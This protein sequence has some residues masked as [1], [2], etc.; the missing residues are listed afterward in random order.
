MPTSATRKGDTRPVPSPGFDVVC[1]IGR[2]EFSAT[3]DTHPYEAALTLIGRHQA[4]GTFTFP[5][6]NGGTVSV[7]VDT[8]DPDDSHSE[9]DPYA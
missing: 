7:H 4:D 6:E 2:V 3:G 1:T 8:S 9:G 5:A